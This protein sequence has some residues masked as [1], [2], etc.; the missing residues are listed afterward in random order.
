M[1]LRPGQ[2][3]ALG[4]AIGHKFLDSGVPVTQVDMLMGRVWVNGAW[5]KLVTP[6]RFVGEWF[7]YKSDG[8]PSD[9]RWQ[10]FQQVLGWDGVDLE[11]LQSLDVSKK[12][13]NVTLAM[14]K[15]NKYLQA[16]FINK[17]GDPISAAR[18]LEKAPADALRRFS[19]RGVVP[20]AAQS[21]PPELA[22]ENVPF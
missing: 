17:L 3:Q 8:A 11:T 15:D 5:V 7:L 14:D 9:H 16:T 21:E 22:E 1:N 10:M 4:M 18:K 13:F 2:Y 12:Y 6:E 19:S 20:P